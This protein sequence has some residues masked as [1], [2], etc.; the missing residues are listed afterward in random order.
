MARELK[1]R[2]EPVEIHIITGQEESLVVDELKAIGICYDKFFSVVDFH[3]AQGSKMWLGPKGTWF[4]DSRLWD[5]TKGEYCAREGINIHFDDTLEYGKYFPSTTT[6][7]HVSRFGFEN[8][9][10]CFTIR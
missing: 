3:K 1:E 4:C 10:R 6:F 7:I 9:A 5:A 2:D 8:F